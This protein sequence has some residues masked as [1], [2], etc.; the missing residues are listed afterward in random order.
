MK[1]HIEV[2]PVNAGTHPLKV[3]I[4]VKFGI[5]EVLQLLFWKR[6]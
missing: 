5:S 1:Y 4:A 2:S 3:N 6:K